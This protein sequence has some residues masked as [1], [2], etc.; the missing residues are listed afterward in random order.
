MNCIV[1]LL[2]GLTPLAIE[3]KFNQ[4]FFGETIKKNFMCKNNCI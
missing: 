1:Y 3:S 2:D 4:N